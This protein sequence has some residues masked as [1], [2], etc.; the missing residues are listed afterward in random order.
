MAPS[1]GAPA[2]S[3]RIPERS[4]GRDLSSL[5]FLL[6]SKVAGFSVGSDGG[7]ACANALP[8]P[9]SSTRG[10]NLAVPITKG[11]PLPSPARRPFRAPVFSHHDLAAHLIALHCSGEIVGDQIGR[12]H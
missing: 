2:S 7:V 11:Y 8:E 10:I 5:G 12:A 9:S 6:P 3:F 1:I 4:R